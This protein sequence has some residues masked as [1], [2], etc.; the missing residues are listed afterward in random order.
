LG[1]KFEELTNSCPNLSIREGSLF[2]IFV[3][4]RFLEGDF[5]I[6]RTMGKPGWGGR[7]DIEFLRSFY[8]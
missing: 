5:V 4:L 1:R 3:Y 2:V 8:H 6:F 7:G